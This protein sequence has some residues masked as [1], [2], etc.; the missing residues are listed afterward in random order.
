MKWNLFFNLTCNFAIH[1]FS[2]NYVTKIFHE[3]RITKIFFYGNSFQYIVYH[4]LFLDSK[5]AKIATSN[6]GSLITQS[7]KSPNPPLNEPS[8][9]GVDSPDLTYSLP[10]PSME[11][12]VLYTAASQ[13][14][15]QI[16]AATL[17][18]AAV[19]LLAHHTALMQSQLMH[20]PG[21]HPLHNVSVKYFNKFG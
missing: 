6:Q 20:Y 21:Y 9:P 16:Y 3:T 4:Y 8:P 19:P 5:M 17:G 12:T 18:N 15:N 11:S 7:S 2:S 14:S 10:T 1:F 13:Q